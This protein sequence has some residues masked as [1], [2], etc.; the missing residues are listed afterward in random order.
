MAFLVSTGLRNHLLDT[1]SFIA[2]ADG[3]EL[4]IYGSPT[5]QAAADALVPSSADDA[6]GSA[7]LLCTVT[8]DDGGT[9]LGFATA[10]ASGVIAKDSA[11]TW[12]GTNLATGYA[13]FYRLTES[14][15]D[16]S[17][18]TTVKRCQGSVG[19][20]GTDLIIANAYMTLGEEQR[21]DSYVVGIPGA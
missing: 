6:V 4:H 13:S 21:I 3:M 12:L 9:G 11:E 19:T 14:T 5:S 17:A 1:G 16:G 18:S 20:V 15:D 8:V 10:A 7:T 2:A